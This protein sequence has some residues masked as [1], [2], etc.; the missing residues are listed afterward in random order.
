MCASLQLDAEAGFSS[1]SHI[2]RDARSA[3]SAAAL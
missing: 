3:L 2:Q 1:R